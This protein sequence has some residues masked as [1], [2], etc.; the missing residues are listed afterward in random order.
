[1]ASSEYTFVLKPTKATT[2][3]RT[4]WC[5]NDHDATEQL[6]GM[7]MAMFFSHRHPKAEL[8]KNGKLIKSTR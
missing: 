1:M 2:W 4:H 5:N 7:Q 8:W 6:Y 3:T